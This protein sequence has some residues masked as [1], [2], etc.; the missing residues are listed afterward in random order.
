MDYFDTFPIHP[1]PKPLESLGSY[2]T[3]LVEANRIGSAGRLFRLIFPDKKHNTDCISD[4]P[5]PS[6]RVLSDMVGCSEPRLLATTFYYLN[7]RLAGQ[8]KPADFGHF[9]V[10]SIARYQRY[11][12]LCLAE[13]GYYVLPWRFDMLPGCPHHECQLLEQCG[14]CGA[15]LP[16]F[17]T[18]PRLALC[19]W[20]DGRLDTCAT[21]TLSEQSLVTAQVHFYD[22]VALLSV[23]AEG[24]PNIAVQLAA[25]RQRQGLTIAQVARLLG[26]RQTAVKAMEGRTSRRSR[27]SLRYYVDYAALLSLTLR[28]LF[29]PPPPV[30]DWTR[31]VARVTAWRKEQLAQQADEREAR[32]LA[33]A[34]E[35]VE[36]IWATGGR[37]N[38]LTLAARLSMNSADIR[39]YPCLTTLLAEQGVVREERWRQHREAELIALIQE[40][41]ER[42]PLDYHPLSVYKISRIVGITTATIRH[43]PG[44]HRYATA[45][46]EK[47]HQLHNM[48]DMKRES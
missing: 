26:I 48:C 1:H 10:G 31:H 47:S 38:I 28:D 34:T 41:V 5:P 39:S 21:E 15:S 12:P 9:L 25:Q 7:Q 14:H 40:K 29:V 24:E 22:L 44:V 37:V 4:R 20:C 6:V 17:V 32:L 8:T 43:H 36:S 33:R 35:A 27:P 11:C 18:P 30:S 16:L 19:P 13:Y 3:R 46:V 2:L 45:L 42:S 23:P